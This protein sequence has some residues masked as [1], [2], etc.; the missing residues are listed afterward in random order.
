MNSRLSDIAAHAG[1]SSATVSRVLNNRA[2]VAE[3]TRQAV[4]T[5]VDVL[6]YQRPIQLK[7]RGA[8]LVGLLIPELENP[9]F[10]M[11]A[12]AIET[13]LAQHGFTPLLCTRTPGGV[14]EDEYIELLGE[15]GV[16]GIVF[17]SGFHADTTADLSH[18]HRLR[19]KGLPLVFINGYAEGI[20]ADFISDDDTTA[21]DLAVKHLVA[22]GHS[23][24]GF[25]VGPERFVPA[26][27]KIAGFHKAMIRY[28]G[29]T[30]EVQVARTL[31]TVEGGHAAAESLLDKGCTAI[32]C[33]SDLMALGAIRAARSR[34][35]A[36]PDKVSV[37]GYDDSMLM[38][39]TDPPLT[40]VRQSVLAM[41]MAAVAALVDEIAGR[42]PTRVEL[43]FEPELVVRGS[44]GSGPRTLPVAGRG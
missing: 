35:L 14:S 29:P 38:A 17:V 43:L 25:A 37:I 30:V 40:T 16:A 41:G 42:P 13:G 19:D 7:A 32:V 5:S 4:L 2:G 12:Q 18:Y 8:G 1:V 15:H 22:L 27:R 31:F 3:A 26:R 34:E 24:I 28:F 10:P 36:V 11:F 33:G 20:D 23:Q 9:I 21:M 6:G 39:F 44:T